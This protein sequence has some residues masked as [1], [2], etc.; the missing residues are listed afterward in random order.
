[1]SVRGPLLHHH[2]ARSIMIH[3][4]DTERCV[5]LRTEAG[6]EKTIAEKSSRRVKNEHHKLRLRDGKPMRTPVL[7]QVAYCR[8]H[9]FDIVN[10]RSVRMA[11]AIVDRRS[12]VVNLC[13][14][15]YFG[16]VA[17]MLAVKLPQRL[18]RVLLLDPV[19]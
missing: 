6:S 5:E 4:V 11:E 15:D 13:I 17:N 2:R 12:I 8:I 1:M 7:R 19:S 10:E 18:D 16:R 3:P 14:G 9:V